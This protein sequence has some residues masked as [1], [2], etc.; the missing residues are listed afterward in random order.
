MSQLLALQRVWPT[1]ST[2][3]EPVALSDMKSYLR[4][5]PSF[6][7]DDELISDLITAAREEVEDQ[8]GRCLLQSS[9]VFNLDFWPSWRPND[10]APAIPGG[11]W[12]VGSLWWDTQR[13][14]IPRPPL[15]SIDSIT[16]LAVDGTTQTLPTNGYLVD[17]Q[18]EPARVLP[19]YN[20]YWPGALQIPNAITINYTA[21]YSPVPRVFQLAI[22][23]IVAAWYENPAD[24]AI[25][26]GAATT[27]PRGVDRI[28]RKHRV[29][30]FDY[31]VK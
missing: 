11:L 22:K 10:S 31:S 20:G 6:T 5:D 3:A 18:S 15:V 12:S 21:G 7:V 9:W 29:S 28:L 17:M 1:G 23:M 27:M 19:A 2:P 13:I 30:G 14:F 16:Y 25:G 26:S 24:Y 8:L 4:V